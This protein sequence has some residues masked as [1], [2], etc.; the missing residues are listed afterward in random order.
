ML[1][2]CYRTQ[3]LRISRHEA[4]VHYIALN[5]RRQGYNVNITPR[6][7]TQEGLRIPDIVATRDTSGLVIDPSIASEQSNLRVVYELKKRKYAYNSGI[8]DHITQSTGATNIIHVPAILSW[9]G[10]WCDKSASTLRAVGTLNA[11][12]LAVISSP[13]LLGGIIAFTRFN[14]VT[15]VCRPGVNRVA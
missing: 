4:V 5:L 6:I 14:Q 7:H 9:R 8:N 11:W 1:Q 3:G 15:T 12:D 2:H 13:V 10:L